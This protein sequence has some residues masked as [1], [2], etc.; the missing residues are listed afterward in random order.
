[1]DETQMTAMSLSSTGASPAEMSDWNAINW[2]KIEQHVKRLQVRIAK[3][4]KESRPSKVK[5]LQRLLICQTRCWVKNLAFKRLE[6]CAVK[7]ACTVLRGRGC[8]D[9]TLLPDLL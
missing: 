5:A 9:T 3:A 4:T 8:G 2:R 1:M 6:P 7:V